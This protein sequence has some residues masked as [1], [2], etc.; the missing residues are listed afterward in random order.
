MKEVKIAAVLWIHTPFYW[1]HTPFYSIEFILH[2]IGF[3]LHSIGFIL[4]E[5]HKDSSIELFF[6]LFW[7]K[8]SKWS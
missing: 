1:I 2:S 3:I 7:S 5:E 8:L 6:G 4:H